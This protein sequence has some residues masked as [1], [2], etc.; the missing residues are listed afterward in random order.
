MSNSL[1]LTGDVGGKYYKVMVELPSGRVTRI[2]CRTTEHSHCR[3]TLT[4]WTPVW[5]RGANCRQ[6]A[7][8]RIGPVLEEAEASLRRHGYRTIATAASE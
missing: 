3:A 7:G 8:R 4:Y 1:E 5:P 2:W 6:G